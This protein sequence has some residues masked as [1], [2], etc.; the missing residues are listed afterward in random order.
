MNQPKT[1][2]VLTLGFALFAMFFGAGN[3]ILPPY[4]GLQSTSEWIWATIGF[5][6]SGILAPFLGLYVVTQNGMSFSD[7]SHRTAPWIV[8]ILTFIIMWSIG[9]IIAIPRTGATTYEMTLLTFFPSMSPWVGSLLFFAITLALSISPSKI[10]DIIGQYLTPLLILLLLVLVFLGVFFPIADSSSIP[11]DAV[12][13]F[14][15]GFD[16]GYQ[17]LDVLASVVFAGIIIAAAHNKGYITTQLRSQIVLKSGVVAVILLFLIY[18]G[19]IFIG[20][21][22]GHEPMTAISRT[23]LLLDISNTILGSFGRY[24]LSIAI[25]LACLTT[26][27]A[28]TTAFAM[29]MQQ[30]TKG[31]LSYKVNVVICTLI[32]IVF[33]VKGVDEIIKYAGTLLHFVYPITFTLIVYL[34]I[35]GKKVHFKTPF[36]AAIF[37][38]TVM[39]LIV[40]LRNN[41][42]FLN[43][44][45]VGYE[46]LPL[47]HHHLEWL[48]PSFIAFVLS[49]FIY[50]K[51]EN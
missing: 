36:I 26:A 35:F 19:L 42:E 43:K 27:I 38:T 11:L 20:A 25:S 31:F 34:W 4:I 6:I 29:F 7:L 3:L 23:E 51:Q 50:K 8:T 17:T 48:L 12:K 30:L 10:V 44:K 45:W 13:S 14:Q 9:P 32:A 37:T 46:L 47:Y 21:H 28:L 2:D 1:I 40:L 18:G 41:S 24:G 22:S 33:S 39:S 15:F 16:E 49:Y 5:A